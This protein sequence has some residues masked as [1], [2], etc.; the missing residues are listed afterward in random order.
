MNLQKIKLH[1]PGNFVLHRHSIMRMKRQA[2]RRPRIGFGND[3]FS[4]ILLKREQHAGFICRYTN[5]M[6]IS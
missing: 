3:L 6:T 5:A 4:F 2:S 1:L